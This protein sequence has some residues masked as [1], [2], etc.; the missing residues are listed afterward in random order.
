MTARYIWRMDDITPNMNW[1]NFWMFIELFRKYS[2]KPL[3]GI[4]PDNRDPQLVVHEAN[5][6]FWKI[7]NGLQSNGVVEFAQ[8]GYQHLYVTQ[9]GGLLGGKYGFKLQSEFAGLPYDL[10]LKKI[11]S[12]KKILENHGIYTDVWMAP[13]HSF[14][15]TTLKA[16]LDA[17][18]KVVTDGIALYPYSMEGL[19]FIPQ[20]LWRPKSFPIGVLTICLHINSSDYDDFRN[21]ERFLNTGAYTI[22]FSEAR[23]HMAGVGDCIL[24]SLFRMSFIAARSWQKLAKQIFGE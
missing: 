22:S 12:G 7:M 4:V 17:G 5:P 23:E 11:S 20:Q 14:D 10:Q 18:F 21:I 1:D 19:L 6:D 24:N 15:R 2:I 3:L 16:L 13:S 8:H 9:E